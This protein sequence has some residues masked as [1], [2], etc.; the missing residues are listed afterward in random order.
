MYS[1]LPQPCYAA[2]TFD[3]PPGIHARPR[4]PQAPIVPAPRPQ[5]QFSQ[6]GMSLGQ[7]FRKLV[8]A[9]L[10]TPLA[11]RPSPQFI[12]P[13]LRV[14]L[15]CLYHQGPRHD[16]DR[17]TA[18][19]H[20]IQ[21]LIDQG[22]VNLGQPSVTTNPLPAHSTHA[23][24][25]PAGDIHFIDSDGT[26][27]FIHMM[28]WDDHAPD[29]I[30][31]VK[32]SEVDGFALSTQLPA[33][34]SLIPDVPPFQ[35]S[36]SHDLVTGHDVPT[37]FV[38]MPEDTVGFDERDVHIVTWSGRIVQPETRPLEGTGSRDDVIREDDEIM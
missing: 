36:Y 24:P 6:L 22:L 18:L 31:I 10:L 9:G 12:S 15:H 26:D 32:D 14:D 2:Q 7:A 8:D 20:A 1:A 17:C 13:Q 29:P 3:R 4:A 25:P 34:L 19:R 27:D 21:D 23:V 30:M 33:H 38:L 16:T 37:A 11:P 5:R 35:L 28:S